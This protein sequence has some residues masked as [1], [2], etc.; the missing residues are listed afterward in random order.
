[1]DLKD[2]EKLFADLKLIDQSEDVQSFKASLSAFGAFARVRLEKLKSTS[3]KEDDENI[4]E[5][6]V[7]F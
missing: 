4:E 1:M 3:K 6:E 7:N 2:N 5:E